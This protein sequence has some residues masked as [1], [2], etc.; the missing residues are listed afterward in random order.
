[1]DE[2]IEKKYGVEVKSLY[3]IDDLLDVLDPDLKSKITPHIRKYQ[4]DL[5]KI[6]KS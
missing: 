3:Q 5:R 1:M 4:E 6:I 2:L